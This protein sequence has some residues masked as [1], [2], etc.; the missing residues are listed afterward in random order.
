MDIIE[1]NKITQ[2]KKVD[3]AEKKMLSKDITKE[4][5][6]CLIVNALK[7]VYGIRATVNIVHGLGV[8]NL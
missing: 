3:S 6:L 8:K 4:E 1:L 5:A 7:R 2:K